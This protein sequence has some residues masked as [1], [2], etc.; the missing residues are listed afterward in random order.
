MGKGCLISLNSE[1]DPIKIGRFDD[2]HCIGKVI[3][4]VKLN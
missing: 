2:I 3:D 4:K 1:Y